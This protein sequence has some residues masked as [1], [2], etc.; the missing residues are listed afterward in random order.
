MSRRLKKLLLNPWIVGVGVT[1]LAD[2]LMDIGI[3]RFGRTVISGAFTVLQQ[4]LQFQV[5]VW[6]AGLLLAVGGMAWRLSYVVRCAKKNR[7]VFLNYTIDT[8]DQ[9]PYR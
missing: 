9:I 5:A 6:Q 8:F 4:P 1:L 3:I 7:P 2:G